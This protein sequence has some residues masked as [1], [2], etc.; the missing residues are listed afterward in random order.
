M[1]AILLHGSIGLLM[2]VVFTAPLMVAGVDLLRSGSVVRRRVWR[3]GPRGVDVATAILG[4]PMHSLTGGWTSALDLRFGIDRIEQTAWLG[5]RLERVVDCFGEVQRRSR[6]R[7]CPI[8]LDL[9]IVRPVVARTLVVGRRRRYGP[10]PATS[11]R[12]YVPVISNARMPGRAIVH[13]NWQPPSSERWCSRDGIG[14]QL[15]PSC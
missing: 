6:P 9:R 7:R 3:S 11:A 15:R 1:E 4:P 12:R 14:S 13:R 5:H 10:V 8:D 2:F